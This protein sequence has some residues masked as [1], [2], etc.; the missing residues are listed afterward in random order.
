M[1]YQSENTEYVL[2]LKKYEEV[3]GRVFAIRGGSVEQRKSLET[4]IS[5]VCVLCQVKTHETTG[6][7]V[8]AAIDTSDS[9]PTIRC[10]FRIIQQELDDPASIQ[11]A[12]EIL[13][14]HGNQSNFI[15]EKALEQDLS[16]LLRKK[17]IGIV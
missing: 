13:A 16:S 12:C 3:Y 4:V 11:G 7:Y 10:S 2:P 17:R 14:E 8:N 15:Y 6:K 9:M 5:S 1:S